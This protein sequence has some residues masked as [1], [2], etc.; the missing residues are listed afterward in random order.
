MS[1]AH[2]HKIVMPEVSRRIS[3]AANRGVHRPIMNLHERS[4][5]VLACQYVDEVIIGA[6]WDVSKDMDC[7]GGEWF[8]MGISGR[9]NRDDQAN[10]MVVETITV[11]PRDSRVNPKPLQLSTKTRVATKRNKQQRDHHPTVVDGGNKIKCFGD[12]CSSCTA[13]IVA[14]CIAVCCCPCVI[15]AFVKVPLLLGIV[16]GE[17][18]LEIN[19]K[20]GSKEDE[21]EGYR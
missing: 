12:Q 6:P 7:E 2:Q 10:Q 15:L 16:V 18:V 8:E 9:E 20:Q 3:H 4:L 13:T 11:P 5:S 17:K 1:D 21:R 19:E 14:D